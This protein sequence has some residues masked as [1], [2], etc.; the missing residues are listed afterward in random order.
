MAG[1]MHCISHE[2]PSARPW[3]GWPGD[4]PDAGA[5]AGADAGSGGGDDG[6]G[7][8]ALGTNNASASILSILL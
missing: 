3:A 8:N 4:E 7:C 1:S 5:D 2:I 6:C